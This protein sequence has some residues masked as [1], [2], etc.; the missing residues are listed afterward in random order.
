RHSWRT[1]WCPRTAWR[2]RSSRRSSMP[3]E[4]TYPGSSPAE[5][6]RSSPRLTLTRRQRRLPAEQE[7]SLTNTPTAGTGNPWTEERDTD[8]HRG[9]TAGT[10][11]FLRSM[12]ERT[13]LELIRRQ[14][15]LSRAQVARDTGLST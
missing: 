13:V 4:Y 9:F 8:Q 14:G 11:S 1:P 6:D 7:R 10:P 3:T 5:R 12:N 2:S 15:P